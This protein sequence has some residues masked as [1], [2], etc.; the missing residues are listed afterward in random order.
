[1]KKN[2]FFLLL[3]VCCQ[4]Q[5]NKSDDPAAKLE[6]SATELKLPGTAG[7]TSVSIVSNS[8]WS[9]TSD[10]SWL[11]VSPASGSGNGTVEITTEK[12][13]TGESRVGM[14]TVTA[15]DIPSHTVSVTQDIAYE[16][17][18][19]VLSPKGDF[20]GAV[21]TIDPNTGETLKTI[22]IST[23]PNYEEGLAYDGELLYYI[24]GR[25]D[26]TGINKIVRF[27]PEAGT[28]VDTFST[29]FPARMD[30]LA[31]NHQN[32]YVLDF[33]QKKIYVVNTENQTIT[34]TIVPAFSEPAIGGLTFGGSRGTLFISSF[35]FG[36]ASTNK[37]YEISATTG[38]VINSFAVS[39]PPFGLA[40][41]EH[42]HVLY[43]TTAEAFDTE[44][45]IYILN[46]DTG[47]VLKKFTGSASAL[48]ADE[49]AQ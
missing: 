29:V 16:P 33:L 41:S 28:A 14:L 24:N 49:S 44:K 15:T 11:T 6:L 34:D 39:V 46:P 5:C 3:T 32:L 26:A 18:Y 40:Y 22:S 36:D 23:D 17:I 27:N 25:T 48:A 30:A 2:I 21:V 47:A 43:I 35:T 12:N 4:M 9:I 13:A 19:G 7:N 8:S 20:N 37:V 1:M 38:E 45:S 10:E 42:A 31:I